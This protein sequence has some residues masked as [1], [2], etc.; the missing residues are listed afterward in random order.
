ML[1]GNFGFPFLNPR[2][3][4]IG[5]GTDGRLGR[6]GVPFLVVVDGADAVF[7]AFHKNVQ[8]F[9]LLFVVQLLQRVQLVVEGLPIGVHFDL[10]AT[11]ELSFESPFAIYEAHVAE[12]EVSL[13]A[14]GTAELG[15][16]LFKL[17]DAVA[18]VD[19]K[20]F[21]I[22][23]A[24]AVLAVAEPIQAIVHFTVP[25]RLNLPRHLLDIF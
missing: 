15:Q 8:V 22:G 14:D 5:D 4:A 11:A 6:R 23:D 9:E 2:L 19:D 24:V 17:K 1:F 20:E 21:F 7:D 25:G 16:L 13:H 3:L 18:T 10:L 12:V